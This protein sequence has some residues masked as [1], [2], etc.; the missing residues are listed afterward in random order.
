MSADFVHDFINYMTIGNL[1]PV[2]VY[3]YCDY[4]QYF[5]ALP[6]LS[7]GVPGIFSKK[8]K[9][10]NSRNIRKHSHELIIVQYILGYQCT[11]Q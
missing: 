5:F 7:G 1:M 10:L 3:N 2:Y 6:F 9:Y 11:M 4:L 8:E